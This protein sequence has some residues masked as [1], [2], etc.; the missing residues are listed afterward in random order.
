MS[1]CAAW[2]GWDEDDGDSDD[3]EG[4]VGGTLPYMQGVNAEKWMM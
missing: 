4:D 3:D 2:W 1:G